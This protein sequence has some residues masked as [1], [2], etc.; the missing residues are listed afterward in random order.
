MD[1]ERFNE[2]VSKAI[3]AL[4]AEFL[5][6]LENVDVVVE[7]NPTP[8]QMG[9]AKSGEEVG[10]LLG[11]YEG[12]PQT[13]RTT[14]YSM[15]LPDKITMFQKPIE[16]ICRND[17]EVYLQVQKTLKHEIAHH[18]GISDERLEEFEEKK[19]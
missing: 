15:V 10:L 17:E 2:L 13:R 1:Y 9:K 4:P 14:G 6:M 3:D 7:D 18:F 8:E 12:V 11:L 5:D 19:S 16:V